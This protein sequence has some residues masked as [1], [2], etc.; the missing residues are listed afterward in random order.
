MGPEEKQLYLDY[1]NWMS[2]E[3]DATGKLAVILEELDDW[4]VDTVANTAQ[5]RM[6]RR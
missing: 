6:L 1:I 4:L 5:P 2:D 3:L